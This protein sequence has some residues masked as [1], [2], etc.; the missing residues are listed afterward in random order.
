MTPGVRRVCSALMAGVMTWAAC[1]SSAQAALV[2]MGTRVVYPS[3]A[4]DVTIRARN[5]GSQ[6]VLAQVWVDDG[7][8]GVAPANMVV[9]FTVSPVLT[10]IDPNSSAVIRLMYMKGP[11]PDDRETLFYLNVLEAP[12]R[13][14][15]T[16]SAMFS[17]RTRIKLFF[18][19][20]ALRDGIDDAPAKLEWQLVQS[21]TGPALEVNNPTPYHVSMS[22][23][24]SVSGGRTAALGGGM[25]APFSVERFKLPK[26]ATAGD[27]Q[28]MLIR[29]EVIND[30]GG[31]HTLERS[32]SH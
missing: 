14:D 4:K 12:P 10:R 7:S 21:A 16:N 24:D 29:Y 23:I 31:R 32:L 20:A 19:P 25:V 15:A 9:P 11:L 13:S 30:Y 8:P 6:P 18:R 22:S 1:A 3:D 27:R 28:K 2:L 26:G 5:E 17:F